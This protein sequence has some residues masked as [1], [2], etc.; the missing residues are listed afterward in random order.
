[1]LD[2]DSDGPNDFAYTGNLILGHGIWNETASDF[3]YTFQQLEFEINEDDGIN[4]AK[5]AFSPDGQI[6]WICILTNLPDVLDYSGY[7]P[8]FLKSTDGGQNWSAPIEVPLGGYY[9]LDAVQQFI[10]DEYLTAFFDPEPVPPRDEIE[11]YIG[12]Y[13]DLSVDAWG[14]PHISGMVCISD[15]AAGNIY[16]NEG[17]M[18]MMHIW[19]NDQGATFTSHSLGDL[20][21]FKADFINGS[22][23]I[24]QY[25]RP[26]VATTMDGGVIFFSW[27]DTH[28][29]ETDDNS[30]PDIFFNDYV[31]VLDLHSEAATNVT[32]FSAGMWT[33]FF[34][35]MSHYVFSEKDG[36]DY[37][38]TIPFVYEEM[39]N[40]DPLEPVQFHYIYDFVKNYSFVGVSEQKPNPVASVSQN[41]PNPFSG[42]STITINLMQKSTL[43]LE[44]HNITG[45]LVKDQNLGLFET[46]LSEIE[47]NAD[48]LESGIYF[49]TLKAGDNKITKKMVIK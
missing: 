3:D 43:S 24:S 25:N 41:S 30:Q 33:S 29:E 45:Q 2:L 36:D 6:G 40:L 13:C 11:Y 38:C 19:S 23:T 49:Y 37:T 48:N 16:P 20:K 14:N 31:P 22:T 10:T 42:T 8:I 27:L 4:D 15:N 21:R 34:G 44:I 26:Q 47:I 32:T 1:M 39:D 28:V 5:I 17:V 18:A 46:G 12:Y 35:C 7:H 9:G